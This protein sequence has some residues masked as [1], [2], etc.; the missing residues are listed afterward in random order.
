MSLPQAGVLMQMDSMDFFETTE[1]GLN[2]TAGVNYIE[3]YSE[4]K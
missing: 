2:L 4:K 1:T 3:K